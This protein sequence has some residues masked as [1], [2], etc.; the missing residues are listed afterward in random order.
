MKITTD[1]IADQ[2]GFWAFQ[3]QVDSGT[4]MPLAIALFLPD[5]ETILDSLIGASNSLVA[6]QISTFD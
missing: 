5:A 1:N 2:F 4:L 3:N 6:R